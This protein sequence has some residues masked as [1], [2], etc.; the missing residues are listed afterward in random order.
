VDPAVSK[1]PSNADSKA[2]L[3]A[4][5]L[6]CASAVVSIAYLAYNAYSPKPTHHGNVCYK[7]KNYV[8]DDDSV[9]MV[10]DHKIGEKAKSNAAKSSDLEGR[11]LKD[12]EI[13]GIFL[14]DIKS[15]RASFPSEDCDNSSS[16]SGKLQT[17]NKIIGKEDFI[18]SDIVRK[19]K[20]RGTT[21]AYVRAGPRSVTHFNPKKVTAAIVT[22][23]GLCPGLNN[24]IRELVHALFHLY[25]AKRV[26]GIRG[27]YNGFSG[28]KGF[29]PIDLDLDFVNSVHHRG[30]TILASSRGGFNLETIMKFVE[31]HHIDQLYIIGGDGT[32]R[33][34]NLIAEELSRRNMNVSVAGIPK[35]IDN[36]IDIIDRSF[37]FTTSVETAQAAIMSAK[38]EATCNLPNGIGIVKLMGRSAGFIA[39]HATMA[40][41]DVDLCL[42]PE[43]A[44]EL[45]GPNGCLPFLL[46]RVRKQGHAVIVVAEGAGEELLGTSMEV[47]AGGN[48]KLPPIGEF[49]KQKVVEYF[50]KND[51]EATV[52]YIDPSYM[53]RSVP[54]NASDALYCMLLA[55][56][57]VHGSMAG[58]TA[59]STGLVNN[60]V[61]YIPIS[62]LVATSPRVMDPN[63]RSWERILSTTRQ[64]ST[65][66]TVEYA[67]CSL[68]DRTMV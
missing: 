19:Y 15:L 29:E 42:V 58:Y 63:G 21:D 30:G 51:E 67:T 43:V 6:A 10:S 18:I 13:D 37:G 62:R 7:C 22:C 61:C 24:V 59:F 57:A 52:K 2:L 26:I 3:V 20:G 33:G 68:N 64:P 8:I 12:C 53:I 48:K 17:Y 49:L 47:D 38:T 14:Q 55:Q 56:N 1:M 25:D 28:R 54:A 9:E 16:Q 41:G 27:G 66:S 39:T 23:G 32:H 34:A 5:T 65:H 50:A 36:D 4:T 45:E 46:E 35:T 40:S 60:R 44:I 11:L 31:K